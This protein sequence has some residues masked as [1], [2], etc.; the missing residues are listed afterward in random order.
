MALQDL[1]AK[2]NGHRQSTLTLLVALILA[3]HL[4]LYRLREKIT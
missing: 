1:L 3:Q 4:L 2:Q